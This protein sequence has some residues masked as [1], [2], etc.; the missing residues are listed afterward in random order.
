VVAVI[1]EVVEV[2]NVDT[3]D[4]IAKSGFSVGTSAK[5]SRP[6]SSVPI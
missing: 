5:I 3:I 4:E 2:D 1:N 6:Y